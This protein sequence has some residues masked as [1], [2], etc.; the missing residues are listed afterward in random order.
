[1]EDR[2]GELRKAKERY[3]SASSVLTCL[4]ASCAHLYA[5]MHQF[6]PTERDIS[7]SSAGNDDI[8]PFGFNHVSRYCLCCG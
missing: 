6:N 5:L 4:S 8:F 7:K 2:G 1:M 3:R